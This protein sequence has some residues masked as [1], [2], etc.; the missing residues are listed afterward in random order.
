MRKLYLLLAVCC[1]LSVA[2]ADSLDCRLVGSWPFGFSRAVA[3][4]S[5]RNLAFLGSGGGAYVL[6]V[7]NP[8]Q[9]VK[10]SEAI[11]TRGFVDGLAFVTDRLYIADGGAG[12]EIW[13]V[14]VPT[15]PQR[16][17]ACA[18]PGPAW[19]VAVAGN[20]AY[21]ADDTFGLRVID[22]SD[23]A[24]PQEVGYYDTPGRA[25]CVAVAGNYA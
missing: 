23:P 14:S 13:D 17:G 25:I 21:M 15:S 3:L 6:D 5:A 20:H 22:V 9:P 12:L 18:A 7:S 4:D 16:L 24:H 8:V 19:G 10:L 2:S 11:H 1:W